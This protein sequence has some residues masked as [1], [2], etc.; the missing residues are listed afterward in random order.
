MDECLSICNQS[1]GANIPDEQVCAAVLY[2]PD[3]NGTNCYFYSASDY[4]Q[5]IK[6]PCQRNEV[7]QRLETYYLNLTRDNDRATRTGK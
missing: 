5:E 3:M 4:L 7:G 2:D 6:V 1:A